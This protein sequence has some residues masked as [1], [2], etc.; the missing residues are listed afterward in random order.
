MAS[1]SYGI[2]A[3]VLMNSANFFTRNLLLA[4][5][6]NHVGISLPVGFFTGSLEQQE[7]IINT[8][9]KTS[10]HSNQEDNKEEYKKRKKE[11][12]NKN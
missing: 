5:I 10:L 9:K 4:S 6:K 8:E 11:V 2:T 3:F 1:V 7:E 12:K